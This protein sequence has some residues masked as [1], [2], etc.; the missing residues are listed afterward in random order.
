M[1]TSKGTSRRC[2]FKR[3][4]IEEQEWPS[5]YEAIGTVHAR[6]AASLSSKVMGYVREVRAQAGDRVRAGQVLWY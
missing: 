2:A 1:S 3:R 5:I 6:T 4:A